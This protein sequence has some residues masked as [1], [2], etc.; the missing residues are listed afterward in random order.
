MNTGQITLALAV[1]REGSITKAAEALF[2]SQP[3]AS[4][5]LKSLEKEIGY[6]IFPRLHSKRYVNNTVLTAMPGKCSFSSV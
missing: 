1:A 2:V 5:M 4:N 6:S 3:T